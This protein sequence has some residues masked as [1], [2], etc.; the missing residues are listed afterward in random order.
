M[1]DDSLRPWTPQC[2]EAGRVCRGDPG[3]GRFGPA[4]ELSPRDPDHEVAAGGESRVALSVALECCAIAVKL[5]AVELDDQ[6][7]F[8]PQ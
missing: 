3:G 6:P 4:N 1:E 2:L 8:G 5:E 7:G